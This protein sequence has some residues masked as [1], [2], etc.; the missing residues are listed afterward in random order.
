MSDDPAS[1]DAGLE[2][3]LVAYLD[4]ELDAESSRRI[5]E[6]LASSAEVRNRL[7]RLDRTWELLDEL[8][9]P[10]VSEALAQSTLEMVTAAASE[11]AQR[12]LAEAPRRR[13]RRWAIAGGSVLAAGVAGFLAVYC[14]WPDPDKELIR[15]LPVLEKLDEYRHG[16]DIEFLRALH[17]QK[18]FAEEDSDEQ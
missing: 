2:E 11:E 9:K 3:Q 10:Q 12:D 8:D 6:L 4:G 15:D 17:R 5:D 7:Q 1:V 18:L 16:E 13:R 14:L